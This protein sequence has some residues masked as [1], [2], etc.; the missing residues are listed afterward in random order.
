MLHDELRAA[1][2]QVG[3]RHAA[4]GPFENVVLLDPNPR[5]L[6]AEPR[7]LVAAPRQVLLGGEQIEPRFQPLVTCCGDVCRHCASPFMA[8][9]LPGVDREVD[10]V[11]PIGG[12]G[13]TSVSGFAWVPCMAAAN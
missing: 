10:L 6:L 11:P 13:V 9:H 8:R 5:Q 2:K 4:V 12:P 1:G 3:E 7:D